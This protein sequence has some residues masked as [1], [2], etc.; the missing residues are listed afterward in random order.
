MKNLALL[1]CVTFFVIVVD[2]YFVRGWFLSIA[3]I[4]FSFINIFINIKNKKSVFIG[5]LLSYSVISL[6][7]VSFIGIYSGKYVIGDFLR[8]RES[9]GK[10]YPA[11]MRELLKDGGVGGFS[12]C[13]VSAYSNDGVDA[14]VRL[15]IFPYQTVDIYLSSKKIVE[16]GY[17]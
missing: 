6:A 13:F 12:K 4:A 11:D 14:I 10:M 7:F 17:D 3:F 2:V 1:V 15:S 8:Y 9:L 5:S 16:R